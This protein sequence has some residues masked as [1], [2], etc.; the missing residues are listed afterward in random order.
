MRVQIDNN[1]CPNPFF[2]FF[3][4]S[5]QKYAVSVV[6]IQLN[7]FSR[8]ART[9][10]AV[11]QQNNIFAAFIFF[12]PTTISCSVNKT[13]YYKLCVKVRAVQYVTQ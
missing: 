9:D 13:S 6:Y 3:T 7:I 8:L 5:Y 1:G 12:I 4:K 2:Y 10:C 11:P